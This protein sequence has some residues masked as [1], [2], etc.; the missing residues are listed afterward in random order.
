MAW[1]RS[2]HRRRH[3]AGVGD[4]GHLQ[5]L[6]A[7][8]PKVGRLLLPEDCSTPGGVP[9]AV[10]SE[11]LWRNRFASDPQIIGKAIRLNWRPHLVIGVVPSVFQTVSPGPAS[12]FPTPCSRSS[13][14]VTTRSANH[15][16]PAQKRAMN[17]APS[18]PLKPTGLWLFS[19]EWRGFLLGSGGQGNGHA[20]RCSG[21]SAILGGFCPQGMVGEEASNQL[22]VERVACFMGHDAC[23]Q[24]AADQGQ[25]AD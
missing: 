10:I 5:F 25:V 15:G 3:A 4:A 18:C 20:G 17:I 14:K 1:Q 19:E 2:N 6:F 7:L 21:R 11:E 16:S 9:V 22:G 12:G 23:L 13:G 8:R 24:R